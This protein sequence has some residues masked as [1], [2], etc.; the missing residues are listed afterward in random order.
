MNEIGKEYGDALF[1][2]AL[3]EDRAKEYGD[4]LQAIQAAFLE[5]PEYSQL[6]ASPDVSLRERI[7]VID[8]VFAKSVP[9]Q[10]L[11][12]VKLLCEK[13]RISCFEASYEEYMALFY[14]S[15][16]VINAKITSAVTL[17]DTEKAKLIRKLE[18]THK[19]KVQAEYLVD[20]ELLGCM[21]VEIDGRILDGSLRHRLREIKD[22]MHS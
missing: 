18:D 12:F 5:N 8:A 1:M 11:S 15:Q 10:V 2:L 20:K 14:A 22:V 6:L 17:T 4:S 19:G 16:R 7:A 9:Q 21:I 3:E 13:G